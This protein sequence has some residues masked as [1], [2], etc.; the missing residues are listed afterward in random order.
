V[1]QPA[2][3]QK[4]LYPLQIHHLQLPAR[5]VEKPQFGQPPVQ[6]R[7]PALKGPRSRPA[8]LVAVARVFAETRTDAATDP[9]PFLECSYR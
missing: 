7:L 5:Y 3:G 6:G 9:E 2:H 8:F 4:L 1:L